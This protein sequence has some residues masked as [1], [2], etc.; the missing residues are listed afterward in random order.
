MAINIAHRPDLDKRVEYLAKV[1][2]GGV[3]GSKVKV[4]EKAIDALE[5]KRG[6]RKCSP[7]EIRTTLNRFLKN[8]PRLRAEA[9]AADPTLD[10]SRPLSETLFEKLYDE[11]GLPR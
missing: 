9:L 11:R 7:E 5:E 8:G 4:I 3:R 6:S 1:M 10:P 2:Y